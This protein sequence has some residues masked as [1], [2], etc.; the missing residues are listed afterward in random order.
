MEVEMDDDLAEQMADEIW[1][2]LAPLRLYHDEYDEG[3]SFDKKH[4]EVEMNL[5]RLL[6]EYYNK[7]T[8]AH[9]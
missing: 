8:K 3:M 2:A 4:E 1:I 9:E 6:E 5:M 7:G